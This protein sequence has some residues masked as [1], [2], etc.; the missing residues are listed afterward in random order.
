MLTITNET[1]LISN[2][3]VV[4]YV[5]DDGFDVYSFS[6]PCESPTYCFPFEIK[7]ARGV[8]FF[9]CWGAS[10]GDH[11]YSSQM[12]AKGGF[13]G[14]SSGLYVAKNKKTVYLHIGAFQNQTQGKVI[15]NNYNGQIEGGG[16][17][18]HDGAGGGATDIRYSKGPWNENFRSRIIVAGGGGSGRL[19]NNTNGQLTAYKG[20]DGGGLTGEA[21]EGSVCESP[22]GMQESSSP[23]NCTNSTFSHSKGEFG[24]APW[25]GW[26]S[27]GGGWYGGGQVKNGAGGGGSGYIGNLI[28]VGKYAAVTN[29]STNIGFGRAKITIIPETSFIDLLSQTCNNRNDLNL[30]SFRRIFVYIFLIQSRY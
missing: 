19:T 5:D 28:G 22:Y 29:K 23:F 12:I 18:G 17:N 1:E 11:Q 3:S 20:G 30:S 14:Y 9:E 21:G 8:Y 10:G 2:E 24:Y 13:G 6:Y 27:G 15:E 4:K 26:S 25:A 7:L 16:N